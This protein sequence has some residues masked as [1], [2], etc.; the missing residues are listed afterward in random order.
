[1]LS[2]N[3]TMPGPDRIP[4]S[5]TAAEAENYE[6]LLNLAERLGDAKPKGLHK[7]GKV[8]HF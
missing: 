7:S 8:I 4:T 3:P 6:A 2:S 5:E 1:M